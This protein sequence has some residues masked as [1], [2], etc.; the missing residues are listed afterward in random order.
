L[1]RALGNLVHN[2]ILHSGGKRILIGAR[3]RGRDAVRLWVIDDGVGVQRGDTRHIFD[4]YYRGLNSRAA[5]RSG[6]G[7]G[8][9]SVRRIAGIMGGEA[10]LD[11]RWARGAAFYLQFPGHEAPPALRRASA[12]SVQ[13]R[14]PHE[15]LSHL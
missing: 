5:A 1:E 15:N 2:A 10:G 14:T 11:P 6:F 12:P 4:D 9:S 7:L 8:L 13:A 3:R